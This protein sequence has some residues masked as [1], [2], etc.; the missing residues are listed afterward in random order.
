MTRPE[1][2]ILTSIDDSV[3]RVTLNRPEVRNA[4]SPNLMAELAAV[5]EELASNSELRTVVLAGAA[6][7]FCS[8][9]D[10]KAANFD[11]VAMRGMLH[12]LA[13]TTLAIRKLQMPTIAKVQ[14]AVVGGGCGL[15]MACDFV[16]TH[17]D[18]KIAYPEIDHGI[19]PAVVAP[20]LIRRIGAGN[21]RALLLAGGAISGQA[22]FNM[23]LATHLA[24][25]ESL[26]QTVDELI[27]RILKGGRTAL[28]ITKHWLNE[29]DDG[30]IEAEVLRGA[31]ISADVLVGAEAQ[32][33]LTRVFGN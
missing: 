33:R 6:P 18:A 31:D 10:L 22:A 3:A 19:C 32:E 23:G 11:P 24:P 15:M 29:L 4:L 16:V 2:L 25:R 28:A 12:D 9:M 1:N 21:A 8:G 30:D 20:W 7:C 27:S 5:I 14:G 17:R 13:R 26:E